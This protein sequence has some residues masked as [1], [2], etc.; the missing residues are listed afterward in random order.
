MSTIYICG[1]ADVGRHAAELDPGHMVSLL[2]DDAFPATP[3]AIPSERHLQLRFHD[4]NL[5]MD[6]YNP[7]E[8]HHVERLIEFGRAWRDEASAIVHCFA[9]VSRSTAAALTL[10]AIRSPGREADAARLLRQRAPHAKP[11]RR[12]TGFADQ[13][14]GLDGRLEAAVE[15]MGAPDFATMGSLVALPAVLD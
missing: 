15:A 11:N 9:G 2:G 1:L 6:G 5:P 8:L 3:A 7:P 10:A 4:I 13:A 12:M 14:L